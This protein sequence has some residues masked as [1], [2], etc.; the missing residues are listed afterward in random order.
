MDLDYLKIH[1][2][3]GMTLLIHLLNVARIRYL[4]CTIKE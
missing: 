3:K 4:G 2:A 1:T